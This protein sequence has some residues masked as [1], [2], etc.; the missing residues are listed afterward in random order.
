[1]D[2]REENPYASSLSWQ[3]IEELES[4]KTLKL[5]AAQR[6]WQRFLAICWYG[7]FVAVPLAFAWSL[8]IYLVFSHL[9]EVNQKQMDTW[10]STV[11][12]GMFLGLIVLG[13]VMHLV[14]F[15]GLSWMNKVTRFQIWVE[16]VVLVLFH[17]ILLM[18]SAGYGLVSLCITIPIWLVIYSRQKNLAVA[19]STPSDL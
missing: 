3:T 16:L 7:S 5:N 4:Q 10:I 2:G 13:I 11:A 18:G 17:L 19:R 12:V 9:I 1:M 8:A 15:I 6:K 14:G